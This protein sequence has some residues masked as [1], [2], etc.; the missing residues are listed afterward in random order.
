MRKPDWKPVV[1]AMEREGVV[2]W[3]DD[4]HR[5]RFL[6]LA[7]GATARPFGPACTGDCDHIG[8]HPREPSS[9]HLAYHGICDC[10]FDRRAGATKGGSK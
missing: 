5:A 4:G 6:A 8:E 7:A 9:A 1:E 10:D 3:G 2:T